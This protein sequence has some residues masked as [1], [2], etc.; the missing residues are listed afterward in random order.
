MTAA[1]AGCQIPVLA[2]DVMDNAAPWP[3]QERRHHQPN[4][5][6]RSGRCKAEDVFRA[7]MPQI[8]AIQLAEY[9]PVWRG[10]AGGADLRTI[11]PT[12][13]AIG[14]G[15][16]GFARTPDRQGGR[17][18]NSKDAARCGDVSPLDKNLWRI[19]V[20]G[21]PP[22]EKRDRNIDRH[23][24]R[25]LEPWLPEL[26]LVAELPGHPLRRR[27][28]RHEQHRPDGENLAPKYSGRGHAKASSPSALAG[29][30]PLGLGRAYGGS[31]LH[32][33][34]SGLPVSG[35]HC[36][37]IRPPPLASV[38][39]RRNLIHTPSPLQVAALQVV[40]RCAAIGPTHPCAH[41]PARPDLVR[42][43]FK[44]RPFAELGP[45]GS[46]RRMLRL[47]SSHQAGISACCR[48]IDRNGLLGGK[49]SQIVR[50]PGLGSGPRQT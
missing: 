32:K 5:L 37:I 4:A 22:P 35:G 38:P 24:T 40:A 3:G 23:A 45:R 39:S 36:W 8:V 41:H 33:G 30:E 31:G 7:I 16:A 13:R 17:D 10:E 19:G 1:K 12:G 11:C 15:D 18:R 49:T 42:W 47:F 25:D 43:T 34:R 44:R 29:Q 27:P 2:L 20:E 46:R 9:D 28:L 14:G 26:R 50:P 48:C 21:V 6:A